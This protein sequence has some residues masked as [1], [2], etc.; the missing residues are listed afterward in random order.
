MQI[1][2]QQFALRISS[3]ECQREFYRLHLPAFRQGVQTWAGCYFQRPGLERETSGRVSGHFCRSSDLGRWRGSQGGTA[4]PEVVRGCSKHMETVRGW[5]ESGAADLLS[6]SRRPGGVWQC[7]EA[8][9]GKA[10]GQTAG[11][12]QHSRGF[13]GGRPKHLISACDLLSL[14]LAL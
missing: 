14:L 11:A 9:A 13:G 3:S 4:V 5:F 1:P 6:S 2:R 10:A 7:R 12:G 8:V